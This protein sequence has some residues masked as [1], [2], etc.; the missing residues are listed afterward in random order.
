MG[1]IISGNGFLLGTEKKPIMEDNKRI[2]AN[3]EY[4]WSDSIIGAHEYTSKQAKQMIKYMD[5]DAFYW[6]PRKEF[7]LKNRWEVKQRQPG[8]DFLN[9]TTHLVGE[10]YAQKMVM[11]SNSDLSY[12]MSGEL[13]EG[14]SEEEAKDI[15][16]EKNLEL[17][18]ELEKKMIEQDM[19]RRLTYDERIEWFMEQYYESGMKYEVLLDNM[20]NED[21]DSFIW[22]GDKITFPTYVRDLK[23]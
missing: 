22:R 15:A 5:H 9:N 16:R 20:R 10:F 2:G 6:S 1:Y 19:D 11:R 17:K 12:L 7:P 14:Y 8:C 18:V 23:I 4:I 13:D 3:I 21:L